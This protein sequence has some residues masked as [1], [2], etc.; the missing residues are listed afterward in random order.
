MNNLRSSIS[1]KN[2]ACKCVVSQKFGSLNV[3]PVDLFV[4]SPDC[5]KGSIS[6]NLDSKQHAELLLG[7]ASRTNAIS[8]GSQTDGILAQ[9]ILLSKS[10]ALE[11]YTRFFERNGF[12]FP[13]DP[14]NHTV[15][16][17]NDIIHL[18]KR[19][20]TIYEL[21]S[22]IHTPLGTT[23][24]ALN[25]RNQQF[26]NHLIFL[27]YSPPITLPLIDSRTQKE[28]RICP[29]KFT[30]LLF[31][32]DFD[33]PSISKQK[34]HDTDYFEVED[35]FFKTDRIKTT[36]YNA[37]LQGEPVPKIK[38]SDDV[39]FRQLVAMHCSTEVPLHVKKIVDF[40]YH[41][42]IANG[43]LSSTTA[44]LNPDVKAPR[45]PKVMVDKL[46]EIA[47][48]VICEE[49]NYYISSARPTIE[50]QAERSVED[51]ETIIWKTDSLMQAIHIAIM[52]D[53]VNDFIYAKCEYPM[54]KR[55]YFPKFINNKKKKH[56][57]PGCS[58]LH[59][60]AKNKA[61]KK[62]ASEDTPNNQ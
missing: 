25:D 28:R 6:Y 36:F 42:Q 57:C 21:H 19:I 23:L 48:E 3:A 18:T 12:F 56:C 46:S 47:N 20:C 50:P 33:Y 16:N 38:N 51:K 41:F 30:E 15:V 10:S 54:C 55:P 32:P 13:L 59:Q 34:Y 22:L 26:L 2:A 31:D 27:L 62:Q 37:I 29:L 4:L 53:Y 52:H 1:Y 35:V 43:V 9:L 8:R 45:L 14:V 40:F 58:N 39:Y 7:G 5:E 49:I 44:K 61:R 60:V 24:E 17:A 11:S